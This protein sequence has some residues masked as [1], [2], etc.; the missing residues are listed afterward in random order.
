DGG[1]RGA[2]DH[3][4]AGGRVRDGGPGRDLG[5]ARGPG[6]T[7]GPGGRR[8]ARRSDAKRPRGAGEDPGDQGRQRRARP[9][10]P[11]GPPDVRVRRRDHPDRATL[12]SFGGRGSPPMPPVVAAAKPPL[13]RC[14]RSRCTA[15]GTA[16]SA[17]TTGASEVSARPSPPTPT[18]SGLEVADLE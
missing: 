17:E 12:K 8:A 3:G 16:D 14:Q 18:G 7:G 4:G 10:S 6:A 13:G 15:L 5:G 1:R 2:A 11:A 9:Q